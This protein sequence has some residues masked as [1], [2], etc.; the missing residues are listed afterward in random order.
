[1]KPGVERG[2]PEP[3]R[4]RYYIVEE[5]S[6]GHNQP[7]PTELSGPDAPYERQDA[8]FWWTVLAVVCALA[9]AGII[10]GLVMRSL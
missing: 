9:L 1:M 6:P 8:R 4:R 5:Y 10:L 7:H 3:W 2:P